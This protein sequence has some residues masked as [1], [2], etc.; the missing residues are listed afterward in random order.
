MGNL[1][2][3]SPVAD[4]HLVFHFF[5][6]IFTNSKT[7]IKRKKNNEAKSYQSF[8]PNITAVIHLVNFYFTGKITII[9]FAYY[10]F[11]FPSGSFSGAAISFH[12]NL[13]S[14]RV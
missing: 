14:Y 2:F 5:C 7:C 11:L 4:G 10:P 12:K 9:K 3:T 1:I 13:R 8:N 6:R